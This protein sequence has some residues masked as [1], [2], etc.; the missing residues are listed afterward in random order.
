MNP[1][2]KDKRRGVPCLKG[3]YWYKSIFV[4]SLLSFLTLSGAGAVPSG[5]A[6]PT[7]GTPVFVT[8]AGQSAD[9]HAV[10]LPPRPRQGQIRVR[11]CGRSRQKYRGRRHYCWSCGWE[12]EG[13]G[14]RCRDGRRR[15]D[16]PASLVSQKAVKRN[17]LYH[18]RRPYRRPNRGSDAL[19]RE[20]VSSSAPG[21]PRCKLISS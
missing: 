17:K 7:A 20:D 4:L 2:N 13:T 15:R 16:N 19:L 18:C 10:K 14:R 8:T 12:F 6:V 9:A 3:K 1:H 5:S 21:S 11:P